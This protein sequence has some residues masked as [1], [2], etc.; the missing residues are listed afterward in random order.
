MTIQTFEDDGKVTLAPEGRLDVKGAPQL[1]AEL[2]K[3]LHRATE[4]VFDM[5]GVNY[6]SSSGFRVLLLAQKQ[7][8][9]Q[10]KMRLIHVNDAV[11]QIIAITGFEEVF[12]VSR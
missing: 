8:N 10:G 5:Q 9:R 12:Y 6:I 7:M 3:V 11:M 4:L 2:Q 1:Q